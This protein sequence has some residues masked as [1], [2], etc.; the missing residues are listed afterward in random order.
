MV[1]SQPP[2][3]GAA[4]R[5]AE[6][7]AQLGDLRRRLPAHSLSPRLMEQLDELEAALQALCAR[8][9]PPANPPQPGE[10][11]SAAGKVQRG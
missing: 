4:E 11:E 5:I 2:S 9:E 1:N 8:S 3:A 10:E 7:Q 6:L